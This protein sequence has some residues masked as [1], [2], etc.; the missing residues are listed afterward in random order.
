MRTLVCVFAGS[1]LVLAD[2][3][4]AVTLG[5]LDTFSDGTVQ[6]WSEGLNSPNPPTNIPNGGPAGVGDHYLQNVSS[7][8]IGAGGKMI[9]FNDAQWTGNYAAA[10]ISRVDADMANFGSTVLHMRIG[11]RSGVDEYASTN[12][13]VL[14]AD[15]KWYRVGFQINAGSMSQVAGT[16]PLATVLGAV[17]EARILSSSTPAFNGE[18]IVAT[19]G[20]DNITAT[21][22]G[23]IDG[24]GHVNVNDLL[25]VAAGFGRATGE[26]NW[27]PSGDLNNDGRVDV[28]DLLIMAGNWG[29]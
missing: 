1:V 27:S 12:A 20:V 26:A 19:L 23:D 4:A 11:L 8:G 22:S 7:G 9:M 18:V 17:Q 5:Q 10:G 16:N 21:I 14:P 6:G 25:I 3:G 2:P 29:T 24:D 28:S 13:V 15:G